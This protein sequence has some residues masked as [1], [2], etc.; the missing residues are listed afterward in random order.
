MKLLRY[1]ALGAEKPG[2]IDANGSI[3][4]LSGHVDDF[5]G[6]TLSDNTISTLRNLDPTCLPVVEA[7]TRIGPSLEMLENSSVLA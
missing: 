1:G 2:M 7:S 4:D 6:L 5:V 3:R